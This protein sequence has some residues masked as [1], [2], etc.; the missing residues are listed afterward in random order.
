MT[1]LSLGMVPE[2]AL[3]FPSLSRLKDVLLIEGLIVNLDSISQLCNDRLFA[4]F[5][6]EKCMLFYQ[7]QYQIMEGRRSLDNCY[8]LT[9]A[10]V[11]TRESWL[12]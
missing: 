8:V 1:V 4:R 10:S 11:Y 2:G 7:N 9:S 6:K 3:I 12:Q 5:T